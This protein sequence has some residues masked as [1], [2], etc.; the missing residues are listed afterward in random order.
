MLNLVYSVFTNSDTE[1]FQNNP[2]V[3]TKMKKDCLYIILA[4]DL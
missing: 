4:G 3:M 2:R 1:N